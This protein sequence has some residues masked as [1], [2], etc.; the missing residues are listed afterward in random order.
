MRASHLGISVL[1]GAFLLAL[2]GDKGTPGMVVADHAL[3]SEAGAVVLRQGGNA[4]DAAV[5]AALACGVVQPASSGLG[6]GGFAVVHGPGFSEVLDFRE[7]A[8]AASIIT[9]Y[10]NALC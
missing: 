2:A 8:P 5:A 9:L 7:I 10:A 4:V 6:G 3:A 1:L